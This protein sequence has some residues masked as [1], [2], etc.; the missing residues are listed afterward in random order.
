MKLVKQ[1][2]KGFQYELEGEDVESLRFLVNQFP[3]VAFSPAKVSKTDAGSSAM[4]REQ[5]INDSLR[6]HREGL[7]RKARGLILREKFTMSDGKQFYRI[8]LKARETMLQILNDIRVESW[9]ILGEPENPETNVFRLTGEK[10]K[11]YHFMRLAGYFEYHF[12]N[13]EEEGR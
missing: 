5:L 7:K 8:M 4:E 3:I 6:L 12:L 1:T 2:Q 10:F 11:Y 13:L 9:R